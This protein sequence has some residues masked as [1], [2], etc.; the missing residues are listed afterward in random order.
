MNNIRF[1]PSALHV[2]ASGVDIEQDLQ[3]KEEHSI[4]ELLDN[5]YEKEKTENNK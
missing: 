5:A 2:V 4:S 1:V 3:A